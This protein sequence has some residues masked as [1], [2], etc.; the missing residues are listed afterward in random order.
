MYIKLSFSQDKNFQDLARIV[1]DVINWT[2]TTSITALM[3]RVQTVYGANIADGLTTSTSDLIRTVSPSPTLTKS[4]MYG[5]NLGTGV[6]KWT[7]EQS[8]Y[9]APNTKYYVQIQ[10]TTLSAG[11]G[12]CCIVG[13]AITGG[14]MTSSA[15][16]INTTARATGGGGVNLTVA[17][18]TYGSASSTFALGNTTNG[19]TNIRHLWMYINDR[20]II[21]AWTVTTT[22]SN[23]WPTTFS[24]SSSFCG[25]YIFGQYTRFDYWNRDSNGIIPLAFPDTARGIGQGFGSSSDFTQP[26]NYYVAQ[27]GATS[28]PMVIYNTVNAFPALTSSWPIIYNAVPSMQWGYRDTSYGAVI[29]TVN[30]NNTYITA[31][32]GKGISNT[33][34]E[35]WPSQDLSGTSFQLIALGWTLDRYGNSGGNIS[36]RSGIF[37]FNGD[38]QPGDEFALGGKTWSVWPM[39]AGYADRIGLAIPKE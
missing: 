13:N 25:P 4:H 33:A 34:A 10:G 24:D 32:Y 14:T 8:S 22:Y 19:Q 9:D 7:L 38:Y 31:G 3:T 20:C 6:Y 29:N 15:L 18:S 5:G 11:V 1:D 35:R 17:G 39:W 30:A 27:A 36:D 37:L 12:V 16:T 26:S 21:M 23:G 2:T 28:M